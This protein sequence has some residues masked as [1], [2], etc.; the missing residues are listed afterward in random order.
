MKIYRHYINSCG[1]FHIE[2]YSVAYSNKTY[3][4]FIVPGKDYLDYVNNFNIVE[5]PTA[6]AVKQIENGFSV[7]SYSKLDLRPD[8]LQRQIMNLESEI[9]IID[10]QITYHESILSALQKELETHKHQLAKLKEE[11]E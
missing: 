2:P 1:E 8:P 11:I 6:G 9:N 4:Y 10:A 7:Y 5:K 3:T